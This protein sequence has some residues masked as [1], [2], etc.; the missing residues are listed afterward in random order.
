MAELICKLSLTTSKC[1]SSGSGLCTTV[2]LVG[3]LF[4]ALT[5]LDGDR[6]GIPHLTAK[7][8]Q[9]RYWQLQFLTV[10]CAPV[11]WRAICRQVVHHVNGCF[12]PV[13]PEALRVVF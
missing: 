5:L 9:V 11:F 8:A 3:L 6:E 13:S 12:E 4:S 2:R 7:N 1:S 10:L